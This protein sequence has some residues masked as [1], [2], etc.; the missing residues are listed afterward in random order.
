M[1]DRSMEDVRAGRTQL[2]KPALKKIADEL[3]LT[4]DLNSLAR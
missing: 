2:A 3:E 4:N 1:M